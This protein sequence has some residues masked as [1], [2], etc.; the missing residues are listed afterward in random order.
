MSIAPSPC[1]KTFLRSSSKQQSSK[2]ASNKTKRHNLETPTDHEPT[3]MRRRSSDDARDKIIIKSDK[4]TIQ[5]SKV[6]F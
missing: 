3:K 5:S 2:Q 4:T 1:K 6:S